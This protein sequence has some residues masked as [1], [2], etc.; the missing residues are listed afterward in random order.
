MPSTKPSSLRRLFSVDG[1]LPP[2]LLPIC[3]ALLTLAIAKGPA[4]AGEPAQPAA[5]T[6][7]FFIAAKDGYG[8]S[9]CLASA[10][11]CGRVVADSWCSAYGHGKARAWGATDDMTASIAGVISKAPKGK[12]AITCAE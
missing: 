6:S 3:G 7:T 8:L 4:V 12:I 9:D 5:K 2:I 1:P 10:G 11:S